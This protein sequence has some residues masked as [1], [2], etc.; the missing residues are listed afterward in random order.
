MAQWEQSLRTLVSLILESPLPN[1]ISWGPEGTVI[2]NDASIPLLGRKHPALGL[3][4][5]DIWSEP[6][7]KMRPLT[8]K[9]LAGVAGFFGD[10]SF[11]VW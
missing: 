6:S 9:A 7:E 11:T 8:R 5:L 2:Y 1:I 10:A 4:F 3:P